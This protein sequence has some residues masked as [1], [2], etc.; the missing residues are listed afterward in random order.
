MKAAPE[1]SRKGMVSGAAVLPGKVEGHD[2]SVMIVPL[3]GHSGGAGA[4][5]KEFP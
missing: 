4:Q 3:V 2:G 5:P 1:A